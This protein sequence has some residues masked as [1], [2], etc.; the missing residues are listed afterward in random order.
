MFT[1]VKNK[2]IS[3]LE[4]LHWYTR[5]PFNAPPQSS[6]HSHYDFQFQYGYG[7]I[8]YTPN[9]ETPYQMSCF[10]SKKL[11]TWSGSLDPFFYSFKP[12]DAE[13]ST[14]TFEMLYLLL[15]VEKRKEEI[16]SMI[17]ILI[18]ISESIKKRSQ[19]KITRW[20]RHL[21]SCYRFA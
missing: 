21:R 5:S 15:L 9:M 16:S 2:W 1:S 6:Y 7:K 19:L 11:N 20:C 18:L 14:S 8:S 10:S 4:E 3:I 13:K 12:Y 17:L